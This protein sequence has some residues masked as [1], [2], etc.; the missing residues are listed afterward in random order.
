MKLFNPPGEEV[1]FNQQIPE[2]LARFKA[3]GSVVNAS[4][5]PYGTMLLQGFPKNDIKAWHGVLRFSRD[6]TFYVRTHSNGHGAM[7]RLRLLIKTDQLMHIKKMGDIYLQEGEANI[8]YS[9]DNEYTHFYKK[10]KEYISLDIYYPISQL[11]K[12]RMVF[13]QLDGF[14]QK[15]EENNPAIL[16]TQ[17]LHLTAGIFTIVH[18]LIHCSYNQPYHSLYFDNKTSLL[19]FLLLM[20]TVEPLKDAWYQKDKIHVNSILQ[21]KS[22]ITNDERY[23]Y[24]IQQLAA[25]VGLNEFKLKK[26][27]KQVFGTGLH[28]F[29][30]KVRM[31]KA[32]ELL[33]CT[34]KPVKEI[35]E[36]I[37][38]K[39]ISSF[40]KVFKKRYNYSPFAWRSIQKAKANGKNGE[41]PRIGNNVEKMKV[42]GTVKGSNKSKR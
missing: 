27:F 37:G 25:Q 11:A 20:Q 2:E 21:A 7:A 18:D 35:G 15:A 29:L 33:E 19:L 14:V 22:L 9:P 10:G 32:Q 28:G 38:Y 1:L 26:G 40:I 30:M 12:W 31:D 13:P 17:P 4:K 41:H 3:S 36:L 23:H 8:I 34:S 16:T 5:G 42:T 24:S 6:A 39:S